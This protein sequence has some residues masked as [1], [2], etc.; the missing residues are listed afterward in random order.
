MLV[1][2]DTRV[3]VDLL[4]C[5]VEVLYRFGSRLAFNRIFFEAASS[6]AG[7]ETFSPVFLL[8]GR[9]LGISLKCVYCVRLAGIRPMRQT[10]FFIVLCSPAFRSRFVL[11]MQP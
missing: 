8:G 11:P 2:I 10:H 5:M 4:N 1:E 7:R 9:Q 3:F 6:Q